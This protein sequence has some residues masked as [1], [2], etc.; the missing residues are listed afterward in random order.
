MPD[1]VLTCFL[2]NKYSVVQLKGMAQYQRF[3]D[4]LDESPSVFLAQESLFSYF[5]DLTW[6]RVSSSAASNQCVLHPLLT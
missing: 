3:T 4:S 5:R 6:E 1:F 2:V